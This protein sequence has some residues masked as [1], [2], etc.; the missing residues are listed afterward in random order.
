MGAESDGHV[1]D[2]EIELLRT[3]DREILRGISW[4]VGGDEHWAIVGP[5][6]AGKTTL[7]RVLA[8]YVWPSRG[9][10]TVLG[11]RFGSYD[12]RELRKEIGVV[13]LA[14]LD[15]LQPWEQVRGVVE[16]GLD[17]TTGGALSAATEEQRA[18]VR[19]ALAAIGAEGLIERDL[20]TLSQGER[21]RVLIAR[22]LVGRPALVLLDEPC[23]GLDPVARERF[24]ADLARLAARAGA[25]RLV[26]VT[27]HVEE[28]PAFVTH[29]LTLRDGRVVASGP[30]ESVMTSDVMRRTFDVPCR[31]ERDGAR[32][33]LTL[34]GA[35]VDAAR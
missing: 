21:Q 9:R 28:I 8:G 17:G 2:L 6:G 11:K 29:L 22:A 10:V 34:D 14:I 5:N 23:A 33:R 31:V 7:L 30:I 20:G 16:S 19:D 12:L 15:R 24:L 27:H 32:W 13:S 1:L 4:R 26:L 25:P 18:R 35:A 3:P